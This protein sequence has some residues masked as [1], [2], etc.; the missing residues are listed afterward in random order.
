[1]FESGFARVR[2]F[3]LD[4]SQMIVQDDSGIP[5]SSF[6]RSKWNLK[7][8]G[9]YVGPIELFKQHDQPALHEL[10]A[11]SNPPPLTIGF[12]YQYNFHKANLIVAERN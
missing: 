1:M 9:T 5:L 12:G 8:F 11:T 3:I 6:N 2:D 4:H 10:F 7:L